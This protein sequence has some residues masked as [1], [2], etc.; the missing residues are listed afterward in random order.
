MIRVLLVISL[1]FTTLFGA[2][3][4]RKIKKT[5]QQLNS[6]SKNYKKLNRQMAK[7]AEAIMRLKRN[8]AKQEK[9]IAQLEEE[10]KTKSTSYQDNVKKLKSL[11]TN[12]EKLQQRSNEVEQ[13]LV[14]AIARSVSLGVFLDEKYSKN[15][16][17]IIEYEVLKAKLNEYRKK[18]KKLRNEYEVA[19]KNIKS[20]DRQT[21]YLKYSIDTIDKKKK[22]LLQT[23]K[24]NKKDLKNLKLAKATY[25]KELKKLLKKQDALKKTLAKL[26]IIKIDEERRREEKKQRERAFAG[27]KEQVSTKNMPKVK[28]YGKSYQSVKTKR[29]RGPKTIAPLER[30]TITK[31]YG[32]YTDPIYGI[33]VFNESIAMK[34]KNKNARVRNVFNG[35][36]IYADKTAV[37]DNIVIIEH[38]NGLHTIYA[39]LS[40]IAPNIR[41]GKRI[42]KG[43]VIGRVNDELIFE[44]TQKTY[45][46]NPI[47][48]FR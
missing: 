4:E 16:D 21:K 14:F 41:K 1:I 32:T 18:I 28:Q 35:K 13:D 26:N 42:K 29:Y 5:S 27:K 39:N 37:L 48:L 43:Y 23:Q 19:T 22:K 6:Y 11:Q 44:V 8:I 40:K 25:K 3:V 46:I 15:I 33:K 38:K 36:V 10:L 24:Q 31:K 45:H 9:L 34:P 2:S 47:R 12:K 7:T 30:Y 17:S 20:I